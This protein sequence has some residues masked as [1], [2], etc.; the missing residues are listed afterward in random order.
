[1]KYDLE[2]FSETMNR[3]WDEETEKIAAALTASSTNT[4]P[5]RIPFCQAR[6]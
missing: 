4:L 2:H 1:M 5:P 6:P 3:E